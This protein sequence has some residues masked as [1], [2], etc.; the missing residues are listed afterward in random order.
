MTPL[1]ST[2]LKTFKRS[3]RTSFGDDLSTKKLR[4]QAW[5]HF[6]L[7]D[8]AWLRRF[9]TN[10]YPVA[11]GVYR[12]NHP[13]PARLGK[14]TAM[15]IKTVLNLRRDDGFSPWILEKE[16]CERLGLELV[17]AK[18]YSRRSAS[19][20]EYLDLIHKLRTLPRPLLF[21][22]KSGADSAGLAAAIYLI[23]IE[24]RSVAQ[25][26]SQ[27]GFKFL[28]VKASKNGVCDH[29]LDVYEARNA[30]CP[31]DLETWFATEYDK[32]AIMRSFI[33]KR[34]GTSGV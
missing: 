17:V 20:E 30:E 23:A 18:M 33:A 25:A 2:Q 16:A 34:A 22:C 32:D 13:S 10:F 27:L 4:R 6:Q 19:G 8:H 7:F 15:G 24:G 12:S 28:H 26:R 1:L 9:W 29:T 31:I 11:P 14:Y 5:W 3:L 21:H